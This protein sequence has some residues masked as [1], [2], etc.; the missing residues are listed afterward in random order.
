MIPL[1]AF[2]A[3]FAAPALAHEVGGSAGGL[4]AWQA[5]TFAVLVAAAAFYALGAARLWG[6]RVGAGRGL[7]PWRIACFS[8]GLL[9][10][11][12]GLLTP[13]HEL[14]DRL[15]AAHMLQHVVLMTVGAPLLALGAGRV[16]GVWALPR[17]VRPFAGR[18]LRLSRPFTRL[19]VATVLQGLALWVW[20]I[21]TVY[22]AALDVEGLHWLQHVTLL[23]GALLFWQA[24]LGRRGFQEPGAAIFCLFLTALHTGMLG[25]LLTFAP[26]PIYLGQSSGAHD[27]GLTLVEDQQLA[28]LVMWAP[29]GLIYAVA[30]LGL[31]AAWIGRSSERSIDLVRPT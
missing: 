28:G 24:L 13:L 14:G 17:R 11:V 25:V 15:F 20:H 31:A 21:P 5:L 30:A 18:F 3:A 27:F 4:D 16:A 7:R 19:D 29:G 26:S 12:A 22:G 6:R 2:A 8:A 23:G 9:T 1:A 10:L